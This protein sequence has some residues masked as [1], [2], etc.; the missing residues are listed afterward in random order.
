MVAGTQ[1]GDM[2]LL[3][4]ATAA[5]AATVSMMAGVFLD[6][7]SERDEA[8]V[9]AKACVAEIWRDPQGALVGLPV[10]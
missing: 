7:E 2:I 9:E 1:S 8:R 4:G 5:I 3:A 6:L 10:S